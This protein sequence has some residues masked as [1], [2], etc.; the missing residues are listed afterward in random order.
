[1]A[2]SLRQA[3]HEDCGNDS[4]VVD[5]EHVP[6]SEKDKRTAVSGWGWLMLGPGLLVCLADTEAGCLFVAAQS[7]SRWGYSLLV[8]QLCLTPVLFCVQELTVRLGVI[9]GK[10]HTACIRA[11]FGAGWAWVATVLLVIC[12]VGAI[13]S[14]MSGVASV[15]EL[16]GFGRMHSILVA[17]V[18]LVTVVVCGS[19]RQIEVIAVLF[20]MC[21]LVFVLTMILLRPAPLD[22]IRG[23]SEFPLEDRHFLEIITANIGA[24]I[25]PWMIYFQQSAVVARRMQTSAELEAERV[26]TFFGSTLT[27]LIMI[28]ILVTLAAAQPQKINIRSLSDIAKAL[29]PT[30]GSWI[31]KVVL[32]FGFLGASMC[33]AFVVSLTAAWA[34]CEA[35]GWDDRHSLDARPFDAPRFYGSFTIVVLVGLLCLASGINMVRLNICIGVMNALLMPISMGFL[36]ALATGSKSQLP[37]GMR[38]QGLHKFFVTMSFSICTFFALFSTVIE[39][40]KHLKPFMPVAQL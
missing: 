30:L 10:G 38:V 40:I 1:M 18:L 22:V 7:G 13:V 37:V 12:C 21:E 25:M 39:S 17:S 3:E 23:A 16:W 4:C 11:R 27:Q 28:G 35:S 26:H 6:L 5:V 29:E 14:E 36:Y 19:Y 34:I 24:V 8:L 20:G 2:S 15:A 32:S 31:S 9:T 33:G